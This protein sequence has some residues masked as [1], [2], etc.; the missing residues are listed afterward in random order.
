MIIIPTNLVVNNQIRKK[1]LANNTPPSN[2]RRERN[3]VPLHQRGEA[4]PGA[5]PGER[6]VDDPRRE[7]LNPPVDHRQEDAAEDEGEHGREF[8]AEAEP[9]KGESEEQCGGRVER[10]LVGETQSQTWQRMYGTSASSNS[11]ILVIGHFELDP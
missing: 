10:V 7:A 3:P 2:G 4:Q 6:E 9:P 11:S 8:R 1:A 5:D